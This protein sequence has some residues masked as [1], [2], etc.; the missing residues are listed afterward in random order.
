M[1]FDDLIS[2]IID[3]TWMGKH[4][5]IIT[6]DVQTAINSP[7]DWFGSFDAI[8]YLRSPSGEELPTI[9][10]VLFSLGEQDLADTIKQSSLLFLESSY[11][12]NKSYNSIKYDDLFGIAET[13]MSTTKENKHEIA[14]ARDA[15]L[16]NNFFL[17]MSFLFSRQSS[18][19]GRVPSISDRLNNLQNQNQSFLAKVLSNL[20]EQLK[21]LLKVL[22]ILPQRKKDLTPEQELTKKDV[23]KAVSKNK[24][25]TKQITGILDGSV[26]E[27]KVKE[28]EHRKL[29]L[30]SGFA[31][32]GLAVNSGITKSTISIIN[33]IARWIM[34]SFLMKPLLEIPGEAIK[35]LA[36]AATSIVLKTFGSDGANAARYLCGGILRSLQLPELWNKTELFTGAWGYLM[37]AAP[38]IIFAAVIIIA[39][40]KMSR[41]TGLGNSFYT[42]GITGEQD[43]DMA[44][45][46]YSETQQEE[47]IKAF[48]QQKDRLLEESNRNYQELYGFSFKQDNLQLAV[49]LAFP[50]PVPLGKEESQI[51]WSRFASLDFIGGF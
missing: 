8:N 34:S 41:T 12:V 17:N 36:N 22:G 10:N 28:R 42:F 30:S 6:S 35:A 13:A 46:M 26:K 21:D 33:E 11:S 45:A 3:D 38:Y 27:K 7:L 16:I 1:K 25:L 14:I 40:I 9:K 24:R 50:V 18:F 23:R 2:R 37:A 32:G 51:L 47:L 29:S 44:F 48:T 15:S 20:E 31:S 49:D 5:L 19:N 4:G 43:P 39:A